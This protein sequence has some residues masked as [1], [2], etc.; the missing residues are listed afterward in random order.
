MS[1]VLGNNA[2]TTL[3]ANM[4]S[5][6]TVIYVSDVSS[7]PA[8]GVG[9]YFNMTIESTTGAYEI[10]RVTQINTSSFNVTR[11]QEGTIAVP[12]NIGARVELRITVQNLENHFSE[13]VDTEIGVT[14]QAYDAQ[15][16]DIAS[17][18]PA[19]GT[20]IVGNGTN[21][22]ARTPAQAIENYLDA[23]AFTA[24]GGTAPNT[25]RDRAGWQVDVRDF[26]TITFDSNGAANTNAVTINAAQTYVSSVG[27]GE[28]L[29]P[30]GTIYSNAITIKTGVHMKGQGWGTVLKAKNGLNDHFIQGEDTPSLWAGATAGGIYDAGWSHLVIDGNR[31]NQ[32][33]G[34]AVRVY[35]RSIWSHHFAITNAYEVGLHTKFGEP[36][37]L[38]GPPARGVENNIHDFYIDFCGKE[39]LLHE[40]PNDS[41]YFNYFLVSGSQLADNTYDLGVCTGTYGHARFTHGHHWRWSPVSYS[42]NYPRY[43]L[44]IDTAGCEF[45]SCDFEGGYTGNILLNAKARFNSTCAFYAARNGGANIV[46]KTSHCEIMG[47]LIGPES[48]TCRGIVLGTTGGD[49]VAYNNIRVRVDD[50]LAGL[51]DW[52]HSDGNNIIDV[53]GT[54]TS[55]PVEVS[56]K[57][58]SDTFIFTLSGQGSG[59]RRGR[60][61]QFSTGYL[62]R[63]LTTGISAAGTTQT[64]ATDLSADNDVHYVGTV[65]SG[66]GVQ[67]PNAGAGAKLTVI[68]DGANPLNVYPPSGHTISGAA[69]DAA[70]IIV[71]GGARTFIQVTSTYWAA[72]GSDADMTAYGR[73][74]INTAS[75]SAART[76]LGVV[77]GTDVQAY[78]AGIEYLSGINFT[79]E[80]TFKAGVNLEA[81]TDFYAPGGTD[82]SVADGGTGDSGTAW[83]SY[84]PTLTYPTAAP[85]TAAV[86]ARYKILGKTMWIS[87]DYDITVLG[88]GAGNVRFSMPSGTV[89]TLMPL[90]G[91]NNSA[92]S[93]QAAFSNAS[94]NCIVLVPSP[95]L[96]AQHYYIGGVIELA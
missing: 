46:I 32:N 53:I 58:A 10:V 91:Y 37:L 1:I 34:T 2:H 30:F 51:V 93:V 35:G 45:D 64:D 49:T 26:G 84:T 5:L 39:C 13:V 81:N 54:H 74:L 7:F 33:A 17:I 55:G 20:F 92:G 41:H 50:Q 9:D 28:L 15:L 62:K 43:T 3:A 83:T 57:P 14:I 36:G 29:L 56:T 63:S 27:G 90:S 44:R 86:S 61:L 38:P 82:V 96:A 47:W 72:V 4:S 22:I 42:L 48:G 95:L 68:N 16:S 19:D 12:F 79:N 71:A 65:A 60:G 23:G 8:L 67:L 11:A 94:L 6:D 31:D 75:A 70:K 88:A 69:A 25:L 52:T 66:T 80:A 59:E 73:T 85:T 78:D 87:I 18:T 21:F 40:G 89:A 77:I 76:A 24:T